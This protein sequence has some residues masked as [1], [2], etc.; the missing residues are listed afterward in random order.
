LINPNHS[1][2]LNPAHM[3][4]AI[5]DYCRETGQVTPETPGAVSRCIFESLALQYRA[6]LM[7][8]RELTGNKIT[9]IH[10]IGG[11]VQNKLLNQLCA[12]FTECV[13]E[14]GPVEATIIGNLVMQWLALGEVGSLREAQTMIAESFAVEQYVPAPPADLQRQWERFQA[15]P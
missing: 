4:I 12:D 14:A 1:R 2:F 3:I 9:K 6:V 15:L 7:Q 8:L 10:I 13:V 11:G 5:G